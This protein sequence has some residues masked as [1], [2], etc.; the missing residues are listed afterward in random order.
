M[1]RLFLAVDLPD[2]VRQ[3]VVA[4]CT[5]V[6]NARWV[7]PH[8][9][10]IT[11]RFLGQTPDDALAGMVDRL[12]RVQV[13]AFKLTLHGAGVFPGGTRPKPARVLWLGLDPPEP[14]A[15][16]KHAINSSLGPDPEHASF[17][18]HLTLARFT[19][20]PNATLTQFLS[21]HQAYRSA[22]WPVACFHLYKSTLRPDG[23]VHEL[24]A[25]YP[26]AEFYRES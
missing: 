22:P 14:L 11:L 13:P 23:A 19:K 2:P 21:Q 9:L 8:Q 4:L 25:T 18:P 3:E 16:L 17:S 20:R 5:Q 26:F 12:A 7:K 6:N 24:V 15:N 10:H 1:L